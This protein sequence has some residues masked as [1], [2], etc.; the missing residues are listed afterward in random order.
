MPLIRNRIAFFADPIPPREILFA[1]DWRSRYA[2]SPLSTPVSFAHRGLKR[3]SENPNPIKKGGDKMSNDNVLA[4]QKTIIKN[5]A[6]ILS[7]QTAIKKNQGDIK[8]NQKKLDQILANQKAI[9]ANQKKI[10]AK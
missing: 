2:I 9:L 8:T 1:A 10:L 4:N 6:T 7:N 3:P 5:Q